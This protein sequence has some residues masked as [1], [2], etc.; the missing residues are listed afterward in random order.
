MRGNDFTRREFL[1]I[2]ALG[3]VALS[4]PA[5]DL[6]SKSKYTAKIGLQLYT[7]RN[8]IEKDFK[9]TMRKVADTGFVGIESYALP[10]NITLEYAGRV[11]K[12]LGLQVIGMHTELPFGSA[13]DTILKTADIYNSDRVIYAGW[14]ENNKYKTVD[15]SKHMVDVYN[16]AAA[17]L[18]KKGLK[19]GLHNH[20]WEFEKQ[21]GIYPF[22]Y[23]LEN[24]DKDIFFEIDTYWAKT[25]GFN[26]VKV[27]LDFG[28]RA[29]LLHI[30]DGPAIKGEES[31][32]QVPAGKGVMDF[33]SIVKAGDENIKWMIIEFDEYDKNIFD[34]IKDS[35]SYLT[36]NGLAEGNI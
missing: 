15:S 30:K 22:Y 36:K 18:K 29:P 13:R 34:G 4:L 9:E 12:D 7:V 16:E 19:F 14:P 35:Y 5:I 11:F 25:G 24:L 20:W 17:F 31:Y 32:K 27:I 1:K 3:S 10:D 21:D 2:A 33:P 26:P 8:E 23:L 6:F 28:C